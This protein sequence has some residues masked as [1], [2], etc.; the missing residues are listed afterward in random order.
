MRPVLILVVCSMS[1][2]V[3]GLDATIVTVALPAIQRSFDSTVAGLQWTVD[4]Y[5]LVLASLL[6]LA[7]S[8]AD[9]VGRRRVFVAGL[10]V[11][12]LGSLLCALAPSLEALVA[13]RVVQAIGGAALSPV[14]MSIVRNVFEDPRERAQAIGVFASMFGI[15][16]ALGPVL[17]GFLVSDDLPGGRSS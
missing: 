4:A 3:I 1:L 17:G 15:S 9:R 5:T 7:G 13:F 6:L 11:F 12:G 16:M 14:A 2:L 10:T 8:T